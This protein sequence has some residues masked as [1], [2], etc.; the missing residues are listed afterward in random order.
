MERTA[1]D[2]IPEIQGLKM[3]LSATDK[4]FAKIINN[5]FEDGFIKLK[6][7]IRGNWYHVYFPFDTARFSD[8]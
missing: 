7:V 6:H 2:T 5:P 4:Q 3:S 1:D 8:A